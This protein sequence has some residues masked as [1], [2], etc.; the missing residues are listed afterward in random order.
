METTQ[1]T[2]NFQTWSFDKFIGQEKIVKNLL[3]QLTSGNTGHAY[4]FVGPEGQGKGSLARIFAAGL[5]CESVDENSGPC[6]ICYSCSKLKK[7]IHPDLVTIGSESK[8]IKIEEV[9]KVKQYI[10]YRPTDS[11]KKIYLIESAENMTREGANSIL[12]MLEEPPEYVVFL[13]TVNELER[14]LPTVISRCQIHQFLPLTEEQLYKALSNRTH[15]SQEQLELAVSLSGGMIG[16]GLA[17][18][19]DES[20][21]DMIKKAHSF[22]EK[23]EKLTLPELLDWAEKIDSM[24]NC[25]EFLELL[26]IVFKQK[27]SENQTS[28]SINK[29]ARIMEIILET[30]GQLLTN[31]NRLLALEAMMVKIKEV[32]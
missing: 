28:D 11:K 30:K 10:N 21:Y 2:I 25:E 15:A 13:L 23:F 16:R 26:N 4:M 8:S 31:V 9:R 29:L 7:S 1:E 5:L 20:Y 3:R 32:D 19:Q 12:K 17:I 27:L 22:V 14:M 6:G 24:D 18:L